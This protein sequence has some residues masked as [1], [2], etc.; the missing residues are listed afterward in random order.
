MIQKHLATFA[1]FAL[2]LLNFAFAQQTISD[3][4]ITELQQESEPCERCM[5]LKNLVWEFLFSDVD[6]AETYGFQAIEE[7]KKCDSTRCL[8]YAYNTLASTYN[9]R[10]LSVQALHYYFLSL[11][12]LEQLGRREGIANTYNNIGIVYRI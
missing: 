2:L 5:L 7:G 10:N 6:S 1:I 8:A 11:D 4:L 9:V 3:S 12:L